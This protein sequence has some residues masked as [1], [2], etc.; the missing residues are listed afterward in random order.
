M[1]IPLYNQRGVLFFSSR[2]D[3]SRCRCMRFEVTPSRFYYVLGCRSSPLFF[4]FS[5]KLV[6]MIHGDSK[7]FYT[8][9]WVLYSF[10]NTFGADVCGFSQHHDLKSLISPY[11]STSLSFFEIWPKLAVVIQGTGKWV[12]KL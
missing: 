11:K 5:P 1:A 8:T 6:V 4:G 7:F 9:K 2:A 10:L 3:S 12:E